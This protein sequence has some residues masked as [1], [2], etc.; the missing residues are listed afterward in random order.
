MGQ[1]LEWMGAAGCAGL[2]AQWVQ[3]RRQGGEMWAKCPFHQSEH[4]TCF[5]YTPAKDL[6]TCHS[7]GAGGD[8]IDL[9]AHLFCQ[10]QPAKEAFRSFAEKYGPPP[11]ARARAEWHQRN[12]ARAKRIGETYRAFD[13]TPGPL[14]PP[15]YEWQERAESFMAHSTERLKTNR[16]ALAWLAARGISPRAAVKCLLGWNDQFKKI[17]GAAWGLK[18]EN[19]QDDD[20]YIYLSEGLVIPVWRPDARRPQEGDLMRLKIRRF[21]GEGPKYMGVRGG[22]AA[23]ATY[24]QGPNMALV[25]SE[26]DAVM[27]W[28]RHPG[29]Q[30]WTFIATG[31][32]R[33][34][35]DEALHRRLAASPR[36]VYCYDNDPPNERG[37]RPGLDAFNDFWKRAYPTIIPYPAPGGAKDP[38]DA[39]RAGADIDTWLLAL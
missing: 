6:Y 25:E 17:P 15:P 39:F 3:A 13:F 14:A 10:G 4:D 11:D 22:R 31:G 9:Y 7:C 20:I 37:Q 2:F 21:S 38:G 16:R 29:R 27:M 35:P 19:P 8:L 23:M 26:L 1:A 34:R 28:G 36:V 5:H 33:I 12:A 32:A 24:G 30:D 18:K